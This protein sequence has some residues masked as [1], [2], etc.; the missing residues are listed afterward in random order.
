VKQALSKLVL[1]LMK[2]KPL[3][4]APLSALIGLGLLLGSA[5]FSVY[6]PW[7]WILTAGGLAFVLGACCWL[8][9]FSRPERVWRSRDSM[10]EQF[11][12]SDTENPD[13][14]F[15]PTV[16]PTPRRPQPP[17]A[18]ASAPVPDPDVPDPDVPDPDVHLRLGSNSN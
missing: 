7:Y 2:I 6:S 13:A 3:L 15:R 4:A 17:P 12:H 10:H 5:C 11:L 14:A 9:S 16:A 8:C 18:S 1:S